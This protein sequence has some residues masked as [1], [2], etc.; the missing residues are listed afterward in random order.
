MIFAANDIFITRGLSRLDDM[1]PRGAKA[2]PQASN[3]FSH[4]LRNRFVLK[5]L[6]LHGSS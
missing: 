5:E 2:D 3:A 1:A 6:V 4:D